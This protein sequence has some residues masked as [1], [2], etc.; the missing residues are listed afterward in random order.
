MITSRVLPLAEWDRLRETALDLAVWGTI[1][2]AAAIVVVVEDDGVIVACWGTFPCRH[3]EGF[4]VRPDHQKRGGVLRRLFVGMRT[5][6]TEL[7]ATAVVTQADTPD[8]ADLLRAAGA[9]RVP[10]E[11]YL[12][13]VDFGPWAK[14]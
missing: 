8:V 9:T 2:P 12:L 4:W 10:G 1:D 11:S 6:L 7:G 14:G 5:V 3:V 13:P